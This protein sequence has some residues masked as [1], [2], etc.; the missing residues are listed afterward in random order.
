M[1]TSDARARAIKS[2][3][4]KN[5]LSNGVEQLARWSTPTTALQRAS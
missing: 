5:A 1:H 4:H 3:F 2:R